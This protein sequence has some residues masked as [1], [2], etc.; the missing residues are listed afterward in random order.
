[1]LRLLLGLANGLEGLSDEWLIW[2]GR[3]TNGLVFSGDSEPAL[4]CEKDGP[5]FVGDCVGVVARTVAGETLFCRLKGDCR[6]E[7]KESGEGRMG[8]ACR[9]QYVDCSLNLIDIP[10]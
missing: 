10:L 1:M 6:P 2:D 5:V 3:R 9:C 4:V 7:S 8:D